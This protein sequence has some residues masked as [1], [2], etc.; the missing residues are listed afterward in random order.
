MSNKD[1]SQAV[2]VFMLANAPTLSEA[3]PMAYDLLKALARQLVYK[4]GTT[5]EHAQYVMNKKY[6]SL[7]AASIMSRIVD[8]ACGDELSS[9]IGASRARRERKRAMLT[10]PVLLT[11]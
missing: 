10:Q 9:R 3:T 1:L 6:S 7:Y 5:K 11:A 8:E 2:N 4:I